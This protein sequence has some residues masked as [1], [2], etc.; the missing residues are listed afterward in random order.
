MWSFSTFSGF[1]VASLRSSRGQHFR[2]GPSFCTSRFCNAA[3]ILFFRVLGCFLCRGSSLSALAFVGSCLCRVLPLPDGNVV[4]TCPGRP[5]LARGRP[6]SVACVPSIPPRIWA[7]ESPNRSR[8]G[9]GRTPRQ[10]GLQTPLAA[11]IAPP[12]PVFRSDAVRPQ[13]SYSGWSAFQCGCPYVEPV[14]VWSFGIS[15]G[16]WPAGM[17]L[18]SGPWPAA[19]RRECPESPG[20]ATAMPVSACL[21]VGAA[22]PVASGWPVVAALSAAAAPLRVSKVCA[23]SS[24]SAARGAWLLPQRLSI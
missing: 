20:A 6:E 12:G 24:D 21:P 17:T 23:A 22:R 18:P 4:A 13:R 5:S 1:S 10:S 19:S 7:S 2:F 16:R 14:S 11:R 9:A 8:P 3:G 15:G